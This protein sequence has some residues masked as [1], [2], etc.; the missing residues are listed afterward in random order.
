MGT[1]PGE[2]DAIGLEAAGAVAQQHR[3]TT[4][5]GI[6]RHGQVRIAVAIEVADRH[7]GG[8]APG[9]NGQVCCEVQCPGRRP[10]QEDNPEQQK[11]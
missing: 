8:S 1:A 6:D 10:G 5:E 2:V 7:G 9:D 3:D 4:R 11:E